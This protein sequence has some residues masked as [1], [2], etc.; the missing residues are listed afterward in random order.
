MLG[1]L[2]IVHG[3]AAEDSL[4]VALRFHGNTSWTLVFM[5]PLLASHAFFHLTTKARHTTTA[6]QA[7]QTTTAHHSIALFLGAQ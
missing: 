5:V 1:G 2:I 6:Q 7:R 4:P 3:L